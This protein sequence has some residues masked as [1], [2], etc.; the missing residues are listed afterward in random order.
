MEVKFGLSEAVSFAVFSKQVLCPT[1]TNSSHHS[2]TH[3]KRHA[4]HTLSNIPHATWAPCAAH[5]LCPTGTPLGR[6]TTHH[7]H[8]GHN[9]H[10]R[11]P[12]PPT[13]VSFLRSSS[14][15][16][17]RVSL[18]VSLSLWRL[19]CVTNTPFYTPCLPLYLCST[20]MSSSFRAGLMPFTE[21]RSWKSGQTEVLDVDYDYTGSLV[22]HA[23]SFSERQ[24]EK[25]K[26]RKRARVA[27]CILICG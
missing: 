6:R 12:V 2:L 27:F 10:F 1:N 16:C 19:S 20:F 5:V 11:I 15:L 21:R 18:S 14:P 4:P 13:Y 9:S 22:L 8:H 3:T 7:R 25:E 26:W 17:H 23:A 24:R